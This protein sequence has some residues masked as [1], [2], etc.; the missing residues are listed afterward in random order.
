MIDWQVNDQSA[1]WL[2]FIK[3]CKRDKIDVHKALAG[4]VNFAVGLCHYCSTK[5]QEPYT[6]WVRLKSTMV[7]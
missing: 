4:Q 1:E 3:A 2:Q 6:L 7:T 5:K